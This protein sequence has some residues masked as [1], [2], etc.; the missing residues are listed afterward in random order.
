VPPRADEPIL[1]WGAASSAGQQSLQ[2][3]KY[4]GYCHLIATASTVHHDYLR[5]LG[6]T[7]VVDYKDPKVAELILEAAAKARGDKR[8]LLPMVID[9]I[10]S[11]KGSLEAIAKVAQKGS[12]VAVMLPVILI[13]ATNDRAP[14]YSMEVAEAASWAD[15]VEVRGVRTHF[16]YKVGPN[17]AS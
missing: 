8:P 1:V 9:C 12:T 5:D 10:G 4:Y 13:H 11:Q 3:L 16:V 2:V 14:E 6:A 17:P 15:G 7:E